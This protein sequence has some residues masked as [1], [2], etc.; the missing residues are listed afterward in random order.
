MAFVI[1]VYASRIL[2]LLGVSSIREGVVLQSTA[3][4]LKDRT[5]QLD[6]VLFYQSDTYLGGSVRVPKELA[7]GLW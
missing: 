3:S 1:D 4:L 7:V 5:L 6:G 2:W